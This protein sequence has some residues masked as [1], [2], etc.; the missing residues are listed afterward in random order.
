MIK[1]V[2]AMIIKLVESLDDD[3]D[4]TDIFDDYINESDIEMEGEDNG[5][6]TNKHNI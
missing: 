2:K 5:N 3:F 4:I 1:G 6:E